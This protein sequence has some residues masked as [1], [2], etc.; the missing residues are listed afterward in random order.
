M[1][2]RWRCWPAGS[3]GP[4]RW[5]TRRCSSEIAETGLLISEWPPGAE[6]LRHRFLIRNRVI[7]AATAG[8][9]V[10]EAAARSGAIQ[11][12]SRV[13]ALRRTAM[14]VPGP[15]TS[16]MSVG[17]HELLRS[18]PDALLVTGVEQVLEAV[19]RIGEYLAERPRGQEHRRDRLDEESARLLEAVP[20]RGTAT[21][22]ELAGRS[23][24]ALRTVLRRLSLLELAGLV[25]RREG[26]FALSRGSAP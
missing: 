6:P 13:L 9:V 19:G 5:A 10:V 4:T 2:V 17:C 14:V 8:T 23:G 26:G 11:T 3:I 24:L 20:A 25:E 7:A 12:M 1:G 21:A 22:E 16:A 15:V 18:R